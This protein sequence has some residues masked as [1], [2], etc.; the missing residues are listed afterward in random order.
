MKS[1]YT[2]NSSAKK[3]VPH[4]FIITLLLILVVE[5]G[6]GILYHFKLLRSGID[7]TWEQIDKIEN[8]RFDSLNEVVI[9]GDSKVANLANLES[10]PRT[11]N[12]STNLWTTMAGQYF[13]L[14]RFY[15][16]GAKPKLC[17]LIFDNN[18]WT[19]DMRTTKEYS[20]AIRYF[21]RPLASIN[22]MID[23]LFKAKRPDLAWHMFIQGIIP[24][25]R[26]KDQIFMLSGKLKVAL[27]SDIWMNRGINKATKEENIKQFI[28]TEP[29]DLAPLA[30]YNFEKICELCRSNN[31]KLLV[32]ESYIPESKLKSELK[33]LEMVKGLKDIMQRQKDVVQVY[34]TRRFVYPNEA[35]GGDGFHLINESKK[36]IFVKEINGI[37]QS[38]NSKI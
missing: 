4:A 13:L 38:F 7:V 9:I 8:M 33:H 29:A 1:L 20:K 12:L 37:I 35:F 27:L 17:V 31:T 5:T 24:S 21:F 15:A 19:N 18:I 11:I 16:Q 3:K 23:L 2:F 25:M 10:P 30:K 26:L 28:R 36:D 34:I 14:K 22:N 32:L 6:L